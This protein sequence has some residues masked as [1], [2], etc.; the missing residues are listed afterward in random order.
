LVDVDGT[1][2]DPIHDEF[3]DCIEYLEK[4]YSVKSRWLKLQENLRKKR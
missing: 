4:S 2:S 1:I 3:D